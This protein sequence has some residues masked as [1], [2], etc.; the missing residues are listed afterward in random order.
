MPTHN[1][2]K[3]F[4]PRSVALIGASGRAGSVGRTVLENLQQA[5]FGTQ[6]FPVNPKH[7]T[8]SGLSTYPAIGS[9]PVTPDL[10][11][12]ATPAETV[13]GLVNECGEAGIAGLIILSA[14][15]SEVGD[16]GRQCESQL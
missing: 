15:F 5:G 1:L 16:R 13:P 8:L 7:T 6:I 3:I 10:A 4:Q 12:I 11:I 2:S 9:L 14:G